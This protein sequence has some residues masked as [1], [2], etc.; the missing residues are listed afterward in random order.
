MTNTLFCI[1]A[2]LTE[3][4]CF[5]Q[6]FYNHKIRAFRYSQHELSTNWPEHSMFNRVPS[7]VILSTGTDT[8]VPTRHVLVYCRIHGA[9]LDN[10]PCYPFSP[11]NLLS[12]PHGIHIGIGKKTANMYMMRL[13]KYVGNNSG[14]CLATTELMFKSALSD[15]ACH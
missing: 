15:P 9:R 11:V 1:P 4:N 5:Q 2:P 8:Q 7:E 6:E 3:P 10:H 12:W 14:N 13:L